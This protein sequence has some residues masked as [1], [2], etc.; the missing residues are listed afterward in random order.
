MK[1]INLAEK[2]AILPSME[3]ELFW[4]DSATSIGH[5]SLHLESP[6]LD[7]GS[8][9]SYLSLKSLGNN[10]IRLSMAVQQLWAHN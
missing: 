6:E 5:N 10:L 9:E 8:N 3:S 2:S 7:L 4:A 1:E